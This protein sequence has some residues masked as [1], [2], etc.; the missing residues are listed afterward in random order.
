MGYLLLKD[1]ET[2]FLD[3]RPADTCVTLHFPS[4]RAIMLWL[5]AVSQIKHTLLQ[6][7]EG[8]IRGTN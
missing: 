3:L 4:G 2:K 8:T 6:T 5:R 1:S 7:E